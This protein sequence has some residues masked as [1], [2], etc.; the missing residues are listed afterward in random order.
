[1]NALQSVALIVGFLWGFWGLYVLVMG[2]YRAKLKGTLTRE[3][4]I[5]GWP[6]YAIGL[7]VDIVANLTVF[8]VLMLELPRELLVT[9]RLKRHR[10][11]GTGWRHDFALFICENLLDPLDPTGEHCD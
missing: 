4:Y 2:L 11:S 5:M 3:A 10:E 7:I 6:Y 8:S 1:M 9:S